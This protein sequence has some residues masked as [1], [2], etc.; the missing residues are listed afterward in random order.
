MR[1]ESARPLVAATYAVA[2]ILAAVSVADVVGQIMPLRFSEPGWRI[3]VLGLVS[4]ALPSFLLAFLIACVA[5]Y[6]LEH[7]RLLQVLAGLSALV[8]LGLL[9]AL[10]FFAMDLLTLRGRIDVQARAGF[11]V[12]M[13]R[14]V[15]TLVV[16]MAT[17]AWIAYGGWRAGRGRGASARS[18]AKDGKAKDQS[19]ML[20]GQPR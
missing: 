5:A 9:I 18:K 14:A 6:F 10:P 11:D 3:G 13:G 19:E 8:A 1:G 16:A 2:V 12:G 17:A 20:I 4:L 15:V 7:Q